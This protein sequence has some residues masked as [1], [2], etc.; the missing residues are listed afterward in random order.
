MRDDGTAGTPLPATASILQRFRPSGRVNSLPST[1]SHRCG[2]QSGLSQFPELAPA[3]ECLVRWGESVIAG[4]IGTY[5]LWVTSSN[6]NFWATREKNANDPLDATFVY[7]NTRVIYNVNTLYS[8][9]PFHAPNYDSPVGFPCDYEVNFFP[10]E[11]F[12]GS[13]PL[14]SRRTTLPTRTSF[15]M[16][17]PPRWT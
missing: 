9:S 1:S 10:D 5:R 6:I 3:R 17:I 7:G 4:S 15:S 2:V 14:F 16:M 8:G 13:E 12:L 11:K